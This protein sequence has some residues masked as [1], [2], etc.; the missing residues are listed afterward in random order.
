VV[1][2]KRLQKSQAWENPRVVSKGELI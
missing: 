2:R 1:Q